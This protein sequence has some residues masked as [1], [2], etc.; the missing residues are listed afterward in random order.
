M[1]VKIVHLN[2]LPPNGD[3]EGW[4]ST[5]LRTLTVISMTSWTGD[6][7]ARPRRSQPSLLVRSGWEMDGEEED[8]E[9]G[10]LV[11]L[12]NGSPLMP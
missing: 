1:A 4:E 9:G 6:G 8:G 3:L 2:N 5:Y 12:W 11:T 7:P 10:C